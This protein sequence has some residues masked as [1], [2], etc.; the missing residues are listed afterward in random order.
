MNLFAPPPDPTDSAADPVLSGGAI[1]R[2]TLASLLSFREPAIALGSTETGRR[3]GYVFERL[4]FEVEESVDPRRLE[5]TVEVPPN[6]FADVV[7]PRTRGVHSVGGR[8]AKSGA[9]AVVRVAS[10]ATER[11]VRDSWGRHVIEVAR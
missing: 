9:G 7:V 11:R 3:E 2:E 10:A 1:S 4:E 6:T 8:R 5:I